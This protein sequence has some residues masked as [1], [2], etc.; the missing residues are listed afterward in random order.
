MLFRSLSA[1]LLLLAGCA[2]PNYA[3]KPEPLGSQSSSPYGDFELVKSTGNSANVWVIADV[4]DFLKSS[5][6]FVILEVTNMSSSTIELAWD[7]FDVLCYSHNGEQRLVPMEP[8][9]LIAKLSKERASGQASRNW[10]TFFQT[11]A[12]AHHDPGAN[13]DVSKVSRSASAGVTA[14]QLQSQSESHMIRKLDSHL[15]R[16]AQVLPHT[17]AWGYVFFPFSK[18]DSYKFRVKIGEDAHEFLYRLRSY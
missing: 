1:Y 18:S 10:G 16:R 9:A 2:T 3:L 13:V 12:S 11:L 6:L 7:S 17:K 4:D 5:F 8:E 14:N 15:I